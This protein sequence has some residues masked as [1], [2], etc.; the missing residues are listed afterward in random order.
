MARERIE[1][2]PIPT[3]E[4]WR[5]ALQ[6]ADKAL[7][8]WP[9]EARVAAT[10]GFILAMT[11]SQPRT[12]GIAEA[13]VAPSAE[14]KETTLDVSQAQIPPAPLEVGVPE[15]VKSAPDYFDRFRVQVEDPET[16][17]IPKPEAAVSFNLNYTVRPGDTLSEISQRFGTTQDEILAH[18]KIEDPNLIHPGEELVIPEVSVEKTVESLQ[19]LEEKVEDIYSRRRMWVG[20]EKYKVEKGDTLWGIAQRIGRT[21]DEI[22]QMNYWKIDDPDLIFPR[23]EFRLPESIYPSEA[24]KEIL[25]RVKADTE[26]LQASIDTNG[27]DSP[28]TKKVAR[29]LSEYWNTAP[30]EQENVLEPEI[31]T[32]LT[33]G[34]K[35]KWIARQIKEVFEAMPNS[36]RI[37]AKV[38]IIPRESTNYDHAM[39]TYTYKDKGATIL[40]LEPRPRSYPEQKELE[41]G[42]EALFAIFF[43]E[44]GHGIS[45]RGE[46]YI[47]RFLTPAEVVEL[48]HEETVLWDRYYRP[49]GEGIAIEGGDIEEQSAG[50]VSRYLMDKEF[51][52]LDPE[53]VKDFE[54]HFN[55]VYSKILGYPV[56]LDELAH[57][58]KI[59]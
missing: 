45:F 44:E 17:I 55:R 37:V 3:V 35:G 11:G 26:R 4:V 34:E 49:S 47:L 43:H 33:T 5:D 54:E 15:D 30:G 50:K 56:T 2:E 38:S 14:G 23:Q 32:D 29:E 51:P 48:V 7:K 12:E 52:Y 58:L 13:A 8:Q 40:I 57:K 28:E 1:Q 9:K 31:E 53:I 18:N 24:T 21:P 42:R 16:E 20:G 59:R 25:T 36:G 19:D 46:G 22:F 6:R 27:I 10:I 39:G 41:W